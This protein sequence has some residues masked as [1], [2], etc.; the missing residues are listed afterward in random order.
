[1]PARRLRPGVRVW[2]LNASGV[3][4][5]ADVA[6]CH[7]STEGCL[8]SVR[9]RAGEILV[10]PDVQ[11]AGARGPV[12]ARD[13]RPGPRRIEAL[14][15]GQVPTELPPPAPL[16]GLD[17]HIA[18]VP[19]EHCDF[20]RL[21]TLLRDAGIEHDLLSQ[22]GWS[23]VRL[24][25]CGAQVDDWSW[26]DELGVLRLLTEWPDNNGDVL[27]TR[28]EETTLRR[29]VI[30]AMVITSASY[31]A[32][33]TPTYFPVECRLADVVRM[34]AFTDVVHVAETHGATVNVVVDAAAMV[35]DLGY[36]APLSAD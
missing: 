29:R 7:P 12:A 25:P 23:A 6:E 3:L 11:L 34:P 1:M 28:M 17:G 20:G 16:E 26:H 18:V 4:R 14:R 5:L 13:V 9:T 33:W 19:N 2:A 32:R 10:P 15:P 35:C 31:E 30:L 27:R 8:L 21:S 24:G 22:G 36:V